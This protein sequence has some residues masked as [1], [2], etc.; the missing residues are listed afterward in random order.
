VPAPRR[1]LR[2]RVYAATLEH[3]GG[4]KYYLVVS[5]NRRNGQLPQVLAVRL[6]TS[7]K[8]LIP[9]VVELDQREPFTGRVLCDD[10]EALYPNEVRR[11]VGAL[12]PGAMG[13]VE[14][15]LRAALDL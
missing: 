15:G 4:E 6:T 1:L 14:A 5:N 12:S 11:D 2:G 8:P 10:I 3:V 9:T 13:R 7:P